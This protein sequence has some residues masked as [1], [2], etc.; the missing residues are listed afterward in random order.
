VPAVKN[1]LVFI[2]WF[3]L[4]AGSL[5]RP[6]GVLDNLAKAHNVTT[7]QIAI[8]WLL[9]RANTARDETDADPRVTEAMVQEKL[10]DIDLELPPAQRGSPAAAPEA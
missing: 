5:T 9:R 3:P 8:A 7:S 10:R 4:A 2:P 6:G 1:K